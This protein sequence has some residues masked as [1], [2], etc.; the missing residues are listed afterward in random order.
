SLSGMNASFFEECTPG[1][2]NSEGAQGNRNGFFSETYGAGSLRYFEILA[3][4][5]AKG[6]PGMTL[7]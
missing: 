1:Y 6:M 2:Y 3:E 7:R 4:W 5:R